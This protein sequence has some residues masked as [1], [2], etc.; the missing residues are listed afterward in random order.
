MGWFTLAEVFRASVPSR[1]MEP[2]SPR[3]A[4]LSVPVTSVTRS[5]ARQGPWFTV[6]RYPAR[7]VSTVSSQASV[8]PASIVMS[9]V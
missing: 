4:V 5:L 1:S 2:V 7:A 8:A 9:M 6:V 3:P